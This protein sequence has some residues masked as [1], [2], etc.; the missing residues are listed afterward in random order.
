MKNTVVDRG[1]EPLC[2][3]WE[4]C[5]LTIRWIDRLLFAYCYAV[6]CVVVDRGIEPLC[7][8]WESCILTIRWIDQR[9][10]FWSQLAEGGGFEPPVRLPARQFSKLLVSATH[11]T[12]QSEIVTESTS[13]VLKC[14]CKG[15][16]FF[17]F[18]QIFQRLFF[19][20]NALFL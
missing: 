7:Q 1:I 14:G 12:F 9:Y 5:I 4:S 19:N 3:D 10:I 6:C 8:D 17:R 18:Y 11:P 16:T 20:K 2:Q 13:I 15:T